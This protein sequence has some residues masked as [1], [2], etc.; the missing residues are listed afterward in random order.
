MEDFF[1]REF[2][3]AKEEMFLFTLN[4]EATMMKVSDPIMFS[5]CVFQE[6]HLFRDGRR[7]RNA[8]LRPSANPTS[9]QWGNPCAVEGAET[10]QPSGAL[11]LWSASPQC[12]LGGREAAAALPELRLGGCSSR[13]RCCSR[14]WRA[15][16]SGAAALCGRLLRWGWA[17]GCP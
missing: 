7:L 6:H 16:Q 17:F 15:L 4:L 3:D 9:W 2:Q 5:H 10:N 14:E 13:S 1:V 12:S 8:K 11:P